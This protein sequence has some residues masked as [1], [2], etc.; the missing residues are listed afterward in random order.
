MKRK[1]ILSV[2]LAVMLLVCAAAGLTSC[3]EK[4]GDSEYTGKWKCTTGEAA[5]V[6]VEADKILDGFEIE[7]K[8]DGTAETTVSG[9]TSSGEW[10]PTDDGFKLKSGDEELEFTKDGENV[11]V[12]YKEV[13]ITFE[14][15]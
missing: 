3:G 4:Y 15:E 6:T 12:D 9:E 10:E 5:G 2:A 14:K 8:A 1:K 7:L 11:K 13:K